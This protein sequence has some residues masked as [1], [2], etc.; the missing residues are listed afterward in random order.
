MRVTVFKAFLEARRHGRAPAQHQRDRLLELGKVCGVGK[1]LAHGLHQRLDYVVVV[2]A[3]GAKD[4]VL[5][6]AVE[7]EPALL[8]DAYAGGA[9]S[10]MAEPE[11]SSNVVTGFGHAKANDRHRELGQTDICT[12][13]RRCY[14]S[15]WN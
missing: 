11:L 9:T 15:R 5:E 6:E 2:S 10:R 14:R 3:E 1:G 13:L 12:S 8:L 7:A 4:F